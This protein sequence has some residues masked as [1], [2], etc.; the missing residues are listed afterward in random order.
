MNR[1]SMSQAHLSKEYNM[2]KYEGA[3]RTICE[4][5]TRW[6]SVA[7]WTSIT[8][9]VL[10]VSSALAGY[11]HGIGV[12][13]DSYSDE[14]QFY[15]PDRATA[16]NWIEILVKVRG[17][18]FGDFTVKRREE[19][20]NQGFEFN[21]SRSDADTGGMLR[22]GQHSGVAKQVAGGQV[23]VVIVFIGANDFINALASS[24]PDK[25]LDGVLSRATSNLRVAVDTILKADPRVEVI[26]ST[27]PDLMDLPEFALAIRKGRLSTA[28]AGKYSAA[29][30][31]YNLS[32]RGMAIKERRIAIMDL[33]LAAQLAPRIGNDHVWIWRRKLDR[34]RPA[35]HRDHVFLADSRHVNTLIQAVMANYV[36][37]VLN[38]RFHAEISPLAFA[39]IMN[40]SGGR[41]ERVVSQS[42]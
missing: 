8:W 18:N 1:L 2:I 26:L 12:I 16:R 39:E 10:T 17:L 37:N 27:V 9:S 15:P 40:I 34:I 11:P 22:S 25:V 5:R 21:W 6:T 41:D 28:L 35:N 3:D 38:D 14:Y 32:M 4:R 19:P 31:R 36:I 30:T 20:R 7:L 33:A 23:Q 24:E 42:Q 29:I 13:G